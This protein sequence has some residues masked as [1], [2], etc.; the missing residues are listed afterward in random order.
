MS[1]PTGTTAD[2]FTGLRVVVAGGT[3]GIGLACVQALK[4]RGARVVAI[5]LPPD[6][7]RAEP[8]IAADGTIHSDLTISNVCTDACDRACE[9]LGGLD[10]VIHSVG[11]SARKA[12]DGPPDLCSDDGWQAALRLNLDSAFYVVRWGVRRLLETPRDRLGQRGSIAVIGSVLADSPSPRHFGTIGY[13]VAKAGL[14]GLVRNAAATYASE[15]IRVNLLKPGLVDTPMAA[16][17]I[18]DPA[19]QNYL[20]SKQPLTAGPVSADACAQAI[21]TLID[22]RN[23]GLTGASLTL[24]GG[25]SVTDSSLT[26]D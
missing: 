14:E 8:E 19:I 17:A 15:G 7:S 16:R 5:G 1:L 24:D 13:A 25:W 2:S 18:D 9:I 20:R 6:Q 10:A 26:A 12:G 23:A 3:S 4:S 11:G 21:L 22:P